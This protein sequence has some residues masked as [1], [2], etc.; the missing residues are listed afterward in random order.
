MQVVTLVRGKSQ[1][2]AECRIGNNNERE[3]AI[4]RDREQLEAQLKN[5]SE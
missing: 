4:P 3:S 2:D 5:I 1:D